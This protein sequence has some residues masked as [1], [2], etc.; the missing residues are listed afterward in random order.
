MGHPFYAVETFKG[1]L[2][3]GSLP[4]L[5]AEESNEWLRRRQFWQRKLIHRIREGFYGKRTDK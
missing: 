5:P 4:P 2:T 3:A 1:L